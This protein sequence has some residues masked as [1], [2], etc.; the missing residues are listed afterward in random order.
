MASNS[1]KTTTL[2]TSNKKITDFYLKNPHINFDS[3][4]CLV[5]DFLNNMISDLSGSINNSITTDILNNVKDIANELASYKS[6]QL[7]SNTQLQSEL[8]NMK[9]II[10]KLNTDI[11]NNLVVKLGDIKKTYI[12]EVK[13]ALVS[14]DATVQNIIEKQND[15][16]LNKTINVINDIIP[17]NQNIIYNQFELLIIKFKEEVNIQLRNISKTNSDFSI[18]KLSNI[19]DNKYT[20]LITNLQQPI[21]NYITSSEDRLSSNITQMKE[22]TLHNSFNQD[23]INEQLSEF[24]NKYNT[25]NSTNIGKLG[26]DKLCGV[27]N[28]LYPSSHIENTSSKSKQGDFILKR[29]NLIDILFE[30]KQY[31]NNVPKDEVLKFIRDC[32]ENNFS[33]IMISNTSGIATKNNFQIDIHDKNILIY[34]HNTNYNEDIIHTAVD[35]LDYLSNAISNIDPSNFNPLTDEQLLD[36]NQEFQTFINQKETIINYIRDTN[37]KLIQQLLDIELPS[38]HKYLS[39][40]FAT[41]KTLDLKCNICNKFTGKNNKSLASHKK[42]CSIKKND[43]TDSIESTESTNSINKTPD[44]KD[45]VSNKKHDLKDSVSNKTHDLKDSVSNKTPDVKDS[46]SNKTPDVKDSVT[47]KNKSDKIKNKNK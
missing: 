28:K 32:D 1:N 26:E 35:V 44:L 21:L 23:K 42:T 13:H 46:L 8:I 9:D 41:T 47:T 11:T 6:T 18:D 33:G 22:N 37:K 40:K 38:L 17:K 15:I 34:L 14:S 16:I 27:L 4:N 3:I 12:D 20:Q 45:S 36:I 31:T 39:S 19:L 7:F 24:L 10:N 29:N 2:S 5:I 25:N 43:Y 30:N